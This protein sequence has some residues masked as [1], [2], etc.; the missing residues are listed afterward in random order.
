MGNIRVDL[1]NVLTI[2]LVG[3]ASVFIINR[4]LKRFGAGQFATA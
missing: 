1:A 2:G 4:A 3:F